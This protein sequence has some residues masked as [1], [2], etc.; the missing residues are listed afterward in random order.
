[1]RK[2]I[3][4]ITNCASLYGANRSMIE[5]ISEL[6]KKDYRVHVAVMGY[7]DVER[8]LHKLRCK[9]EVFR[10]R[11]SVHPIND[12]NVISRYK[13]LKENVFA[14][15]CMAKYVRKNQIEY[16]HSNSIVIDVGAIAA[17]FAGVKHIWHI[18]EMIP[19]D[20]QF[21]FDFKLLERRLLKRADR[22]ICI[23]EAVR[24]HYAG[25]LGGRVCVIYDGLQC[26][27]YYQNA[28][29]RVMN[30]NILL[31]GNIMQSKGCAE[32]VEAISILKKRGHDDVHLYIVGSGDIVWLKKVIRAYHAG[33]CV[34]VCGFVKDLSDIRKACAIGLMCSKS[35][36]LGRVTIESM[37]AGMYVIGTDSGGT[38][39][40]I[41]HGRNGYLYP[42]G[43]SNKL[44]DVI[45]HVWNHPDKRM[46]EKAQKDAFER[47]DQENQAQK[48]IQIYE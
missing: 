3:L 45:E 10:Y 20:Y 33:S 12:N 32:A 5:L 48:V 8:E 4:F 31:C 24:R 14:A 35:E 46:L 16:I 11:Q 38:S 25:L 21:E 23:S 27:R 30:H 36:A 40:I 43:N 13:S 1:M 28:A 2:G 19:K 34:T 39:E 29:K 15:W 47:F 41:L 42:P 26:E 9:T 17:R 7:N 37:L 22:I 18:R 6:I 44:A